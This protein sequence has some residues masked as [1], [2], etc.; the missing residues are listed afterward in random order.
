MNATRAIGYAL[1]L[2][3]MIVAAVAFV[4]IGWQVLLFAIWLANGAPYP[5]DF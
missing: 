3:G 1:A 5:E 4:Y 2:V